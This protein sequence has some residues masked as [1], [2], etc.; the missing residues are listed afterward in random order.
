VTDA[1]RSL[2]PYLERYP[3]AFEGLARAIVADIQRYSEAAGLVPD[4]VLLERTAV[5]LASESRSE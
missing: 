4:Q 1:L 5:L 3:E 2:L